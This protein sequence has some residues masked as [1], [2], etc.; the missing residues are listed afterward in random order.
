MCYKK[1]A[2]GGGGVKGILHIG[3]LK[4]LSERQP[5]YFPDGIYGNSIG[6]IFATYVAFKLPLEKM[7][8]LAQK[9]LNIKQIIPDISLTDVPNIYRKKG[10]HMNKFHNSVIAMF[11]EA[12]L[13]IQN[14]YIEDADMPLY[15]LSSNIT[16][17]VPT[18]FTKKVLIIDAI[19]ASC[20]IPIAFEPQEIYG[21]L[22]VDGGLLT[23]CISNLVH[24][25]LCITL[26]KQ[27]DT[28]GIIP[29]KI[30]NISPLQY[31]YTLYSMSA[32]K[33]SQQYKHENTVELSYPNL[34]TESNLDDFD[35][36]DIIEKSY[37][38]MDNFLSAQS[39]S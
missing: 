7:P 6:S 2:L 35:V 34:S 13:D 31:L 20:C 21:Q 32:T 39:G 33:S 19:K 3:A 27:S 37:L 16:R 9:Y 1:I 11:Q 26:K 30:E 5:L 25:G 12:G 22:Y 8:E 4:A 36:P 29:K 38:I 28:R 14:K 17:G 23:P 15:I 24:D 10:F 18:I